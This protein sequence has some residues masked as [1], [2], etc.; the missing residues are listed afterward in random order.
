[1]PA[2]PGA[3]H[4]PDTFSVTRWVGSSVP[5]AEYGSKRTSWVPAA[6]VDV[7]A[8][9]VVEPVEPGELLQAES[10]R[11]TSAITP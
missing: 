11:A 4:V 8:D 5:C 3:T 9:D 1:M 6:V 7:T 10:A 2:T